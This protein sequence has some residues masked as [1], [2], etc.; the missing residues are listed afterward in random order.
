MQSR[1]LRHWTMKGASSALL[2]LAAVILTNPASATLMYE[3]GVATEYTVTVGSTFR[4][5]GYFKNT[6]NEAFIFGPALDQ[7]QYANGGMQFLGDPSLLFQTSQMFVDNSIGSPTQFA[8]NTIAPGA[9]F[10]FDM[11]E[12]KILSSPTSS[13]IQIRFHQIFES[14]RFFGPPKFYA[15]TFAPTLPE[16]YI[17]PFVTIAVGDVAHV[18]EPIYSPGCVYRFNDGSFNL[19]NGP[20]ACVGQV[21]EP[22]SFVMMGSGL[23]VGAF[24]FAIAGRRRRRFRLVG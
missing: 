24:A 20:D 9:T 7:W 5:Q 10:A 6:G 17:G 23:M 14:G 21:P 22:N 16:V 1:D 8:G 13:K 4:V 15:S 2:A 3:I 12:F 19:I 11:G 18:S